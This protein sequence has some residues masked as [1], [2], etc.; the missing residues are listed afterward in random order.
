[1]SNIKYR[2]SDD[3]SVAYGE[4]PDGKVFIIDADMLEKIRAVKFYI[5]GKS[6]NSDRY[7]VIDR[8]G[9]ALHDYL[10]EHRPGFEIDH[11]NLDTFDNR[12]CNIRY[13]THQQNQMNQPLQKNNTSGVSGV[14]YYPP[15]HKFRARIKVS[16]KEIH[17]GY[18]DTFEDAVKARNIGMRCMFGQYG[19]YTDVGKVPDWL[20]KKV[21]EKCARHL[22]L[23][24][25][26]AF[27]DFWDG[28]ATDETE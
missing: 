2:F 8:K 14:S 22:E 1:M 6:T 24:L 13:C 16:Q 4:L 26:S 17:L 15:R 21:F 19:R 23:A 10:F 25:N 20:E 11:I 5:G 9:R 12:R 28:G 18:F 27:F 7:Y 3:G